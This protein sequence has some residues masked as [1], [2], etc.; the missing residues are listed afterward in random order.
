MTKD[1]NSSIRKCLNIIKEFNW[2]PDNVKDE[3][4][5]ID[6]GLH[7]LNIVSLIIEIEE[8]FDI[9]ISDN[10]ID[11]RNWTT[12]KKIER[13]VEGVLNDEFR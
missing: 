10:L 4:N 3:D 11:L 5:L 9:E 2:S 7:S 13:L 1:I 6:F 8:I 12:I